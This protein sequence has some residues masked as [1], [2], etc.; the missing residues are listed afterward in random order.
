[1]RRKNRARSG[2]IRGIKVPGHLRPDRSGEVRA[3]TSRDPR[4]GPGLDAEHGS[5]IHGI[6]W[7]VAVAGEREDVRRSGPTRGRARYGF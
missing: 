3:R 6:E 7:R 1:M 4:S 5:G 2:R